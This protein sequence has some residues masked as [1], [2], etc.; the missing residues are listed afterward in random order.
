MRTRILPF[1]LICIVATAC[2]KDPIRSEKKMLTKDKWYYVSAMMSQP[3]TDPFDSI[4][5]YDFFDLINRCLD[6]NYVKYNKDNSIEYD[7]GELKCNPDLPKTTTGTWML[8]S[9]NGKLYLN[10]T[11]AGD[12]FDDQWLEV[13]SL[14]DKEMV[15]YQA[16]DNV[17]GDNIQRSIT[18]RFKR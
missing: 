18:I 16:P 5:Y 8:K 10:E 4:T 14:T 13:I 7:E 15:L 2:K 12:N 1:L 9:E 17:L 3:Y 11:L 6:D